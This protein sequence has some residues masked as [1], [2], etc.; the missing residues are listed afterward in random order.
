VPGQLAELPTTRFVPIASGVVLDFEDPRASARDWSPVSGRWVFSDG[1]QVQSELGRFDL[2]TMYSRRLAATG[3]AQVEMR[4]L[5][6]EMGG[7]LVFNA[8][9]RNSRRGAQMISFAGNGTFLQWG[10]FDRSGV[11]QFQGGVD[12]VNG[13][14]GEQHTLAFRINGNT[15]EVAINGVQLMKDIPLASPAGGYFGLLA[16]TSQVAF[17]N[18]RIEGLVP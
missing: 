13:G 2:L 9:A 3:G 12:G 15:Y 14:N 18:L 10:F 5:Q 17:D 8:P 6:G 1:A 11:F 16:S 7:G 4:L